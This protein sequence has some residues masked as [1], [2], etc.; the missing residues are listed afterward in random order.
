M[1]GNKKKAKYFYDY[2]TT[3][4]QEADENN[5][6]VV[7]YIEYMISVSPSE[8]KQKWTWP[9]YLPFFNEENEGEEHG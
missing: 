8:A 3:Q 6:I 4:L 2:L 7:E 1:I 9:Y 5:P